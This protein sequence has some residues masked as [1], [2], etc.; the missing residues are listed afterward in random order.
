MKGALAKRTHLEQLLY[1]AMMKLT[2]EHVKGCRE[3]WKSRGNTGDPDR[4]ALVDYLLRQVGVGRFL[5]YCEEFPSQV[6][7]S[8]LMIL[9][10]NSASPCSMVEKI[11]LHAPHFHP[12]RRLEVVEAGENYFVVEDVFVSGRPPMAA[13]DLFVFGVLKGVLREYGCC[14]LEVEWEAARSEGLCQLLG[15]VDIHPISVEKFTR[16]RYRWTGLCRNEQLSGLDDYFY[17][18]LSTEGNLLQQTLTEKVEVIVEKVLPDRL[19]VGQVAEQVGVSPRTLQRRLKEE[20]TSYGDICSDVRLST[21]ERMLPMVNLSIGAIARFCGYS[22]SAHF[23]REFK[24]RHH[25]SPLRYRKSILISD[26]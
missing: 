7:T 21:A 22:D 8:P 9:L 23:C 6:P 4:S 2:P 3:E 13:D 1:M 11:T 14:G 5:E 16:W 18:H 26:H 20:G 10:Y 19:S 25:L 12:T 24:K 15:S 17:G